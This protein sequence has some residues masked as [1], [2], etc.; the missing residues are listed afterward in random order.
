MRR[1]EANHDASLLSAEMALRWVSDFRT[2][3]ESNPA[4][5]ETRSDPPAPHTCKFPFTTSDSVDT[6]A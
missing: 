3:P 1:D 6:H 2:I 4:V 5:I